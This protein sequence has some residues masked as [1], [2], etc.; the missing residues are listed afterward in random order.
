MATVAQ[1]SEESLRIASLNTSDATEIA[2]SLRFLNDAYVRAV[3]LTGVFDTDASVSPAANSDKI[4]RTAYAPAA[5][6]SQGVVGVKAVWLN[7]SG[8]TG[9]KLERKSMQDLIGL[10]ATENV[11]PYD[12]PLYYAVR[13]NGDI[14]LWPVTSS[15]NTF[16]IELEV[17]PPELVLT[18]AA[19]GQETTPSAI[20]S[21][22]HRSI[23]LNYA[24][25]RL[26]QYR[27]LESR[28]QFFM[29]EHERG[30]RELREWINEQGSIQGPPVR[31][32]RSRDNRPI[33]YP[34]QV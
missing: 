19:S 34:D 26:L 12:G 11:S 2:L 32:V 4:A 3:G 20:L 6:V 31:V 16:T 17:M 22:F 10:R 13:G 15:G 7:G 27:G 28:S 25:A 18:G 1:L 30:I 21:M 33:R 5:S 8:G 24:V 9:R 29:A 14:E 23:L